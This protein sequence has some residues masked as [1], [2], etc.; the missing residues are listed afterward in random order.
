M[1]L[2]P[3]LVPTAH[4]DDCSI[5]S[6]STPGTPATLIA[7]PPRAE[8]SGDH[9]YIEPS[10][11]RRLGA[12][13]VRTPSPGTGCSSSPDVQAPRVNCEESKKLG[14]GAATA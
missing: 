11:Q 1:C 5:S 8:H 4:T 3:R 6:P 10:S 9:D 13:H 2:T 12:G 14:S 7:T